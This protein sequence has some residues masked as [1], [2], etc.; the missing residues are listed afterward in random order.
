MTHLFFSP[1]EVL[2]RHL[3]INILVL[4]SYRDCII[5][6]CPCHAVGRFLVILEQGSNPWPLQWKHGVLSPRLLGKF[7]HYII[8]TKLIEV[9]NGRYEKETSLTAP[10][11]VWK[12]RQNWM[13]W[14]QQCKVVEK[15]ES[16]AETQC[17]ARYMGGTRL[18][19]SCAKAYFYPQFFPWCSDIKITS[20]KFNVPKMLVEFLYVFLHTFKNVCVLSIFFGRQR[21]KF[22]IYK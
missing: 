14:K 21:I 19:W 5:F 8:L 13:D 3:K 6:S 12:G 16:K 17:F 20:V 18:I 22:Y 15:P 10:Q 11:H 7:W 4:C 9:W 1:E 2:R